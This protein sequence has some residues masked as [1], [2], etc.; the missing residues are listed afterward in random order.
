MNNDNNNKINN[1]NDD[2]NQKVKEEFNFIYKIL[3]QFDYIPKYFFEY[4]YHYDTIYDLLFNEYSNI[5]KKLERFLLIK[6]IDLDIIEK[7]KENKHL[8]IKENIKDVQVLE[9]NDFL[10]FVKLIPLKYIN[11]KACKN[12]QFYF[13]Y[14]FPFFEEILED[15]INFQNSKKTFFITES[16]KER[17]NIFEGLL[18]YKFRTDKK[19]NLDGYFEVENLT[20]MELKGNYTNVNQEYLSSKYNVFINQRNDSGSDYDFAIY[21]PQSKK[22]LLFQSK[23]LIDYSNVR[24]YRKD[25]ISSAKFVSKSFSNIINNGINEVYLIFISSVFYNYDRKEKAIETLTNR[26][27]NCIFY[28]LRKDL[29]YIN[30]KD[31]ISEIKLI[32][33]YIL[34]PSIQKYVEQEALNNPDLEKGDYVYKWNKNIK[35]KE[36]EEENDEGIQNTNILEKKV[37]EMFGTQLLLGK[38]TIRNIMEL[39]TTYNDLIKY[40]RQDSLFNNETLI[41]L[42]GAL[43]YIGYTEKYLDLNHEYAIIFYLKEDTQNIDFDKK[44]GLII[45]HDGV[46]Y[47]I[48]LKDNISYTKY[49]EFISQF[50]INYLYAIGKKTNS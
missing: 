46:Q 37:N 26:N 12:R 33:S 45:F 35:T 49:E 36:I 8:I 44:I 2:D 14:S 4:L 9:K 28:S 31:N 10:R 22:L 39:T 42:L 27:L 40:I 25:Y 1:N 50:S 6:I 30:F 24:K 17:G 16:G 13:Y 32:D 21:K 15:F 38:K 7:L 5:M 41:K 34:L 29:F 3:K 20:T 18:K 43:N 48:D 47:L 19:F 11:I 23:Y